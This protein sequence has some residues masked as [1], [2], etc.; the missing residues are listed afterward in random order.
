[1][2]NRF[3]PIQ[4][5]PAARSFF[6][7]LKRNAFNLQWPEIIWMFWW[8]GVFLRMK[9]MIKKS[10]YC[11][12][13]GIREPFRLPDPGQPIVNFVFENVLWN[14][15]T[16]NTIIIHGQRWLC[17]SICPFISF[18]HI[19]NEDCYYCLISVLKS[20]FLQGPMNCVVHLAV[21]HSSSRAKAKFEI[22]C[23]KIKNWNS[24]FRI[25]SDI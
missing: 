22:L 21:I 10:S 17:Y 15:G 11:G 2:L 1:M 6:F 9:A 18:D 14:S 5:K 3:I 23:E 25:L 8:E 4:A 13:G 24:S 20:N 16:P 19:G 7:I 12:V